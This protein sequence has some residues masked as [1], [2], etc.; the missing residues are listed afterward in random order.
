MTRASLLSRYFLIL[1]IVLV[2]SCKNLNL[3]EFHFTPVAHNSDV[4]VHED[5]Y[6]FGD[7]KG[8]YNYVDFLEKDGTKTVRFA[9]IKL[10]GN[11]P[12][13]I[14][15]FSSWFVWGEIFQYGEYANEGRFWKITPEDGKATSWKLPLIRSFALSADMKYLFR[16]GWN[17]E[18]GNYIEIF[19]LESGKMI[20]KFTDKKFEGIIQ[21]R[22]SWGINF[23]GLSNSFR[24]QMMI[25]VA[26]DTR[27]ADCEVDLKTMTF[28]ELSVS[29]EHWGQE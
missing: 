8:W 16:D 25:D 24:F 18:S 19:D 29:K 3:V 2:G 15:S 12:A 11:G 1:L 10:I 17:K 9:R 27:A 13:F 7:P 21:T 6:N 5:A 14:K 26:G 28:H 4:I 22:D 23:D 20:K